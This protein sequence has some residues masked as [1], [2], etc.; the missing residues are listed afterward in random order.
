MWNVLNC[1]KYL[2]CTFGAGVWNLFLDTHW[3]VSWRSCK[4]D[5]FFHS[6][7]FSGYDAWNIRECHDTLYF[8]ILL[9]TL[10]WSIYDPSVIQHFWGIICRGA[11][12]FS[13]CNQIKSQQIPVES[14]LS[15]LK[16]SSMPRSDRWRQ[17]L[18]D[19]TGN[20]TQYNPRRC[21]SLF[22]VLGTWIQT[23]YID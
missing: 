22:V 11:K 8:N 15:C 20:R 4:N 14:Y 23:G 13:L 1:L 6:K 12:I 21:R 17:F 7:A 18:V 19:L 10:N 2:F 5:W 16:F 9:V 3:S